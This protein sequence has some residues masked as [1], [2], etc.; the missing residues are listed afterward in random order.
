MPL[1]RPE[2]G[3]VVVEGKVADHQDGGPTPGSRDA[4]RRRVHPID[5]VGPAVRDESQWLRI[6]DRERV[7]VAHGHAVARHQ[8]CPGGERFLQFDEH[9]PLEQRS[10]L[11][12]RVPHRGPGSGISRLP[13]VEPA[14]IRAGTATQRT[15]KRCGA[16]RRVAGE[17][18]VHRHRPYPPRAPR[19]AEDVHGSCSVEQSVERLR[20]GPAAEPH[21]HVGC[22][23]LLRSRIAQ[24][25]VVRRQDVRTVMAPHP[26]AAE[27]VGQQR[28]A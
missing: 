17:Y 5:A 23:A 20:G 7:Q 22:A 25:G 1:R 10:R 9:A 12:R 27:R 28:R 15:R 16:D 2:P 19:F 4:E 11:E 21:H 14:S 18:L 26:E 6:R 8:G 3:Q 13:C 24:D